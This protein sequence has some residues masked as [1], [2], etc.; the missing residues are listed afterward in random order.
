[1]KS[2]ESWSA[3]VGWG[4]HWAQDPPT[5]EAL[6]LN[7][8]IGAAWRKAAARLPGQIIHENH[9]FDPRF[10]RGSTAGA[11][12]QVPLLL[13]V[14]CR[15][16]TSDALTMGSINLR[17]VSKRLAGVANDLRVNV[18]RQPL[19]QTTNLRIRALVANRSRPDIRPAH[20][21]TLELFAAQSQLARGHFL[22]E[23]LAG[24]VQKRLTQLTQ[25]KNFDSAKDPVEAL[26]D[27]RVASRRLRAF[28]DVFGPMLDPDLKL[29]AKKPLKRITRAVC[30]LRDW[31]V[32]IGLLRERLG[33]V[34][35]EAASIALED[36]LATTT[37]LRKREARRT[38]KLLRKF[39][40]TELNFALC[41]T[42][43]STI[44]QLPPAGPESASF[45]WGLIEPFVQSIEVKAAPSE[46]L[47][48]ADRLHEL[49]IHFKKLRYALE[50]LE[51]TLGT[52]FEHLYSPVEAMQDLL[53]KH[54][55]LV[56][57]H[58]LAE[59]QR[60]RLEQTERVTLARTLAAFQK[61]LADERR[62]L[63]NQV[64][65]EAFDVEVW[66]LSLR[67]E[68]ES[69]SGSSAPLPSVAQT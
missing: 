14:S 13:Q 27:F 60:R 41:A 16:D 56:V 23:H 37:E 6:S 20:D 1:M 66:K 46:D 24:I 7:S 21:A 12:W 52:A 69:N 63:V 10:I 30:T 28:V 61:Q 3:P 29:R 19:V 51:P 18:S 34:P 47:Q 38:H 22:A 35:G 57:L 49:R 62:A 17:S 11:H 40:Y 33:R 67:T 25:A 65:S 53:G 4:S 8:T 54:H 31:D 44:S 42:L 43:G 64:R 26:H 36:L 5:V 9:G 50:L 2:D 15:W 48:Q 32:Q 58:E 39:D 45:L 59:H 55:D 68:L